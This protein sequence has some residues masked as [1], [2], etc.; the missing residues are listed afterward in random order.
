MLKA[1]NIIGLVLLGA[2]LLLAGSN[3]TQRTLHFA[4]VDWCV[5]D[6]GPWGPGPNY[7]SGSQ[8]SV[9]LDAAGRLHLKIRKENGR[10]YCAEVYTQKYTCYGEHRF[11]VEGMI[12]KMDKNI[13]LGLFVYAS[14]TQEIDIEYSKWGDADK[15]D[16]GSFT[17]QPYTTSGNQHT[18]ISPLDSAQTTHF[19]DWQPG[20]VSFGSMHG[21][22]YAAPNSQKEYIEQWLY[23]GSDNPSDGDQLQTHI[24][25]WLMNGWAPTDFSVME[26]IIND[27][28]Q[29]LSTSALKKKEIYRPHRFN[30]QQN[31]P[32][33]FNPSTIIRWQ[34]AVGSH[35]KLTVYNALGQK[36]KELVNRRQ[37]AG[38]YG[39]KFN[40]GNLPSGVYIYR[41]STTAGFS[42]VRKM[43]LIR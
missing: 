24:N 1:K 39:V 31:V 10:W 30:L 23:S 25:F 26:V 37:P 11:L 4:G 43:L 32:N 29:P 33:P 42:T 9:W 16:V 6:G 38:S 8:Q 13:V 14:D 15:E 40:A 20:Y 17:V 7:W 27:V 2:T 22:Y 12:D 5:K 3:S 21:H 35:V 18:F 34:L 19:F 36:V 28:V 41:L